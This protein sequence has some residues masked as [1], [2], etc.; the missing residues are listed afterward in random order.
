MFSHNKTDLIRTY[1]IS[2]A[3]TQSSNQNLQNHFIDGV[4]QA[5]RLKL[6][7]VNKGIKFRNQ[8]NKGLDEILK[9]SFHLEIELNEHYDVIGTN[10][11]KVLIKNGWKAIRP[12]TFK[13]NNGE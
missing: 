1:K 11:L 2:H 4:T 8:S 7:H 10:I 13:T 6:S 9:K 3:R 12:K 5:N